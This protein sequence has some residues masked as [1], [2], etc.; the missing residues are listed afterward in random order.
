M[1]RKWY[2]FTTGAVL[3]VTVGL[4]A[5]LW[6]LGD[7]IYA[8]GAQWRGWTIS[9][10]GLALPALGLAGC[11]LWLRQQRGRGDA[12]ATVPWLK[13]ALGLSVIAWCAVVLFSLM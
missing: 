10:A 5:I 1:T 2:G 7:R 8:G 4:T 9:M 6:H 12:L 11:A 3:A 13:G